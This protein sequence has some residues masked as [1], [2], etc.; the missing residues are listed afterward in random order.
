MLESVG[1]PDGTTKFVDQVVSFAPA[2]VRF[3][4]FSWA[5][6]L[7]GPYDVFHIHWPEF[8]IRGRSGPVRMVRTALTVALLLRLWATKTP[9]VRTMHNVV[10][11]E[12]GGAVERALLRRVDRCTALFVTLSEA[13]PVTEEAPRKIIRHGHYKG[14]LTADRARARTHRMIAFGRVEPYKNNLELIRTFSSLQDPSAELR[15]VGKASS[16]MAE[17]LRQAAAEDRRV[18]FHFDFVSDAQMVHEITASQL[19]V[20]PY[21]EM[22]NSGVVLVALSLERPVLVPRTATNEILAREVGEEWLLMFDPPLEARH[23]IGALEAT[24]G[25]LVTKPRLDDRDWEAVAAAYAEAFRA[26]LGKK[27]GKRL[28]DGTRAR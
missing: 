13:T 7:L 8:L 3:T 14:V 26:V 27:R 28:K 20:L 4:Y 16:Q 23:L 11:H 25:A 9:V 2:D 15:I 18:G 24:S 22:H 17:E 21:T 19:V 5:R 6:A 10:P 1:A 12:T